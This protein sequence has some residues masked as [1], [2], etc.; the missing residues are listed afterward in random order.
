MHGTS[1]PLAEAVPSNVR[2]DASVSRPVMVISPMV[3]TSSIAASSIAESAGSAEG[4]A[5]IAV[6]P[7][8]DM[9]VGVERVVAQGARRPPGGDDPFGVLG[10]VPGLAQRHEHP[11]RVRTVLAVLEHD[12]FA[13]LFLAQRQQFHDDLRALAV[14]GQA[15]GADPELG[16]DRGGPVSYTH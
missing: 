14:P 13:D 15:H 12:L 9:T 11:Q 4:T 3:S 5:V 16:V 2:F 10:E 8:A 6:Q 1:T 7:R